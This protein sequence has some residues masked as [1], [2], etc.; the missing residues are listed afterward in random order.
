MRENPFI[1]SSVSLPPTASRSPPFKGGF[2]LRAAS[3]PGGQPSL[4]REGVA[5]GDGWDDLC[6]FAHVRKKL[7]HH[8]KHPSSPLPSA[9]PLSRVDFRIRRPE[10][11]FSLAPSHRLRRCSRGRACLLTVFLIFPRYALS[12]SLICAIYQ[13]LRLYLHHHFRLVPA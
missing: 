10:A 12:V 7:I 13:T 6:L 11:A 9:S 4:D 1:V 2:P 5:V 8:F 3:P